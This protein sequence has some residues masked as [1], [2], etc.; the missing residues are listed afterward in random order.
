ML[1]EK[2]LQDI[3]LRADQTQVGPWK[4]CIE[5]RD[6]E[7]ISSFIQTGS[8]KDQ[9]VNIQLKGATIADIDFIAHSKQDIPKLIKEI[10]ELR[11]LLQ[12]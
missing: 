6:Q 10:K 5:G 11:S 1:S 9:G 7:N 2:E 12:Q 4:A 3:E 8:E